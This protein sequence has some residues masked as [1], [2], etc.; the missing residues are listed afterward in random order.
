MRDSI[1]LTDAVY[2]YILCNF[3]NLIYRFQFAEMGNI[4]GKTKDR[5]ERKKSIGEQKETTTQRCHYP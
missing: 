1:E 2:I 5:R 3:T 4:V